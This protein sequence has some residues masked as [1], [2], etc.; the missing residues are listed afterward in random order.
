MRDED[1]GT[2]LS[3]LSYSLIIH[4]ESVHVVLNPVIHLT[5]DTR[6]SL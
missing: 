2:E 5:Q 4:Y 1:E 3:F 6:L